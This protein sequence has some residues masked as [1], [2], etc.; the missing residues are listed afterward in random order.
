MQGRL[1]LLLPIQKCLSYENPIILGKRRQEYSFLELA[2]FFQSDN[3]MVIMSI[4]ASEVVI[5]LGYITFP[6]HVAQGVGE[7]ENSGLHALA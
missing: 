1:A 3:D 2:R 5:G 7:Y 6:L 4:P